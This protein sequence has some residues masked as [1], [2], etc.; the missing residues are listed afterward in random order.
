MTL[1]LPLPTS[2]VLTQ[3]SDHNNAWETAPLMLPQQQRSLRELES[4][5]RQKLHSCREMSAEH[6]S[7]FPALERKGKAKIPDSCL[8]LRFVKLW[9]CIHTTKQHVQILINP[10]NTRKKSW[11]ALEDQAGCLSASNCIPT[12]IPHWQMERRISLRGLLFFTQKLNHIQWPTHWS[13]A[14]TGD[15]FG[16]WQVWEIKDQCWE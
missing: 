9:L 15:L 5:N 13:R 6:N 7:K 4:L 12:A 16:N 2:V 3:A 10:S 1:L 8:H 14:G 11:F